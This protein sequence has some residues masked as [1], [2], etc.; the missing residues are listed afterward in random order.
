MDANKIRKKFLEFMESRGH[1]VIAPAPLVLLDDPTT[2]FTGS[3]M[4]PLLPYLLGQEHA[5]GDKLVDCQPCL[6]VQDID[7][8]GDNR[9]TTCF[10]ML[11]N[12]S[13]GDYFKKEQINYFLDF[14]VEEVGLDINKIYATCFIGDEE[15]GIPRDDEAA[16]IWKEAFK[17]YGIDA[18]IVEINTAENGDKRGI[19]E[20]ERIFFYNDKENWWSRGGGIATTPLGD[21]CGPDSEVFY[22]FGEDAILP[23]FKNT[24]IKSHPAGDNGQFVEIGNQVFMQYRRNEDGSFSELE[25]KNI[26]FGAGL[27]R[28]SAAAIDSADIFKISLLWPIVEELEKLSGKKYDGHRYEM[29]V[30]A[31]HVKG[32]VSLAANDLVPSNKEQGYVMRRLLRRAILQAL[33]LGIED[34]FVAGIVPIVVRIYGE[35]YTEFAKNEKNIISVLEREEK[36]FRQTLRRGLKELEKRSPKLTGKDLF[37]LQDTYG[38]PFELAVEQV[39][40]HGYK[41]SEKY[42]EEF[43][44]KLT[45]Q[46]E[47]S[48]TAT[49][50]RFKGGLDSAGEMN[51]RLHT[52]AHIL[53]S[54]LKEVLGDKNVSQK[55]S[56]IDAERIRLD[57]A[58]DRKLTEDEVAKVEEVVN[59]IIAKNLPVS[60]AEYD[61]DYALDELKAVGAFR[62]RYGDKVNVYTIGCDDCVASCEICGG[63]HVANTSEI[64]GVE[65][66]K[67]KIKKQEASSAG[68]RRIKATLEK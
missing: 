42:K 56:N 20:G 62:D 66:L 38:F 29:Q 27:E 3:G 10:E 43:D 6:R 8:V 58:F 64:A 14:L 28:I 47:R 30:I 17:R 65:K 51:I 63:P 36:T 24:N 50:G 1:A 33:H 53:L 67:F 37:V 12:W 44:A 32:A 41:L 68:V 46:R 11:G 59:G 48:R 55:G 13:L 35:H 26:D 21:P 57:F 54:A 9:H 45:E 49:K 61:T 7:D 31:D 5:K 19:K 18:K 60:S 39:G 25:K 34:N 40:I 4:Q 2:L 16:E 22:D 52:T 23:E 15:N